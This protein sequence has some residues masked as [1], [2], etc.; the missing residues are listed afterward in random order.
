MAGKNIT[1]ELSTV[2]AA[3]IRSA[4]A[5]VHVSLP[6]RVQSYDSEK[7]TAT[8][9]FELRRL[10]EGTKGLIPE[11]LPTLADVPVRFARTT[12]MGTFLPVAEGDQ[13]HVEFTEVPLDAWLAVGELTTPTTV[14]RHTLGGAVFVPGLVP[15][16]KANA[17]D[18]GTDMVMGNIGGVQI[19]VK[20]GGTVEVVDAATGTTA[21]QFVALAAETL[22]RLT[23]IAGAHDTHTHITTATV[24]TGAPGVLAVTAAPIGS[25]ASVA[26]NNLKANKAP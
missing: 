24:S 26:S 21:S 13:G 10:L 19:R 9:V 14:G 15:T 5:D 3:A 11:D 7:Q 17:D 12:T 18:I 23:S 22:A 25:I 6:A 4:L 8:V 20:P 2:I 16:A 1:R